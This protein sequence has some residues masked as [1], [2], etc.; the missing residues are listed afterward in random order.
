VDFLNYLF[1]AAALWIWLIAA[2]LLALVIYLRRHSSFAL[3]DFFYTLPLIGRLAR[4]SKDYSDSSYPGWLN[5]ENTLCRDY[6]RHCTAIS[7]AE[8]DNHIQYLKK[9]YDHG[10]RPIPLWVLALLALLIVLEGLGFSYLLGG[11]MAM[12]GS[13]DTRQILMI[14]IVL[15]LATILVWVTHHAGH[16]WFRTSLLRYCFREFQKDKREEKSFTSQIVSLDEKQSVDDKQP[17]HVQCANRVVSKPGDVGNHAWAWIAAVLILTIA[18]GSTVL[19]LETLH[20]AQIEAAT[21]IDMPEEFADAVAGAPAADPAAASKENAALAGFIMLAIIFIVTQLVGAGVGLRYGFAGK[22]SK[23]AYKA[24]GGHSDYGSYFTPVEHRMMIANSRLLSLHQLLEKHSP[25]PIDFKN[26]FFDFIKEERKRG[27]SY[28]QSPPEEPEEP[29]RLTGPRTE[30]YQAEG[31]AGAVGNGP[32]PPAQA[33]SEETTVAAAADSALSD[34][35]AA[36]DDVPADGPVAEAVAKVDLAP[37]G[38][39]KVA[40]IESLPDELREKVITSL[41]ERK[42]AAADLRRRIEEVL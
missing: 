2:T 9:T 1:S 21:T 6:A 29:R 7:K 41:A 11:F 26:N 24:T 5:V 32:A 28:L 17:D 18:V 27:A 36:A 12:E 19:R 14:A 42:A 16:Q 10:R 39:A 35:A 37:D 4:Y 25:T 20:T 3:T 30:S 33:A 38:K 23:D 40:I 31:D 34:D 22:Q 8:F 13:E 15:V